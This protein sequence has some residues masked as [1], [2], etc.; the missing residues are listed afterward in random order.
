[1][2]KITV[3]TEGMM[4]S[5]CEAHLCSAVRQA[6]P[7][8]KKV[9]ASRKSGEISFIYDENIEDEKLKSIIENTG[10]TFISASSQPYKK[11]GIFGK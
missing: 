2:N 6:F 1:M 3:K 8:A 5:M 4:C 10:Y 11:R 9:A 7:G